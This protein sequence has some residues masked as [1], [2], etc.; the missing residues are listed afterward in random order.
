[1]FTS[2]GFETPRRFRVSE[3]EEILSALGDSETYGVVLRAK[4]MVPSADSDAWLHFD[5]VPEEQ[6]IREGS[7]EVTGRICVIGAD[8]RTD[9]LSELFGKKD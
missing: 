1:M 5:M 6:E 9:R 2:W 4:G 7:P 3:L 8:I